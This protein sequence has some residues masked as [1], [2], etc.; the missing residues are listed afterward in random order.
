MNR[1]LIT[2]IIEETGKK[3]DVELPDHIPLEKLLEPMLKGLNEGLVL[4]F[5]PKNYRYVLSEDGNEW[6]SV[7]LDQTLSEMEV[8]DGSYLRLERIQSFST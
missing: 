5:N 7:T 3:S 8:T 4:T 2:L 6:R 1:S